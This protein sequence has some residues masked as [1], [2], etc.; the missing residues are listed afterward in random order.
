MVFDVKKNSWARCNCK[1]ESASASSAT[2][3]SATP[4]S[5]DMELICRKNMHCEDI[6]IRSIDTTPKPKCG[7]KSCG[8]GE[9]CFAHLDDTG[10]EA[11]QCVK[12]KHVWLVTAGDDMARSEA[13]IGSSLVLL[14]P[15]GFS[16]RRKSRREQQLH[17]FF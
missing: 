13:G 8:S 10:K 5:M 7:D 2:H 3:D 11:H 14:T 12:D 6:N 16:C 1:L 9:Q 17:A 4:E 15:E